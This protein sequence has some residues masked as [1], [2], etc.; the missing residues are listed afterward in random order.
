MLVAP[1]GRFL[2]VPGAQRLDPSGTFQYRHRVMHGI[3]RVAPA[4]DKM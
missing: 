3:A 1:P 2:A 4:V